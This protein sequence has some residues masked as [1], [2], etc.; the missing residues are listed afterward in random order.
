MVEQL[1]LN[2]RVVGSSPTR[3]TTA[4]NDLPFSAFSETKYC[5]QLC[6]PLP[7]ETDRE[8]AS[9]ALRFAFIRMCEWRFEMSIA[10]FLELGL[11]MCYLQST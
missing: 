4:F 5:A 8:I 1:T 10:Q 11:T 7:A 9:S 3:F 6:D 2:Q